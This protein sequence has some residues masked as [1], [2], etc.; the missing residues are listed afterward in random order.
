MIQKHSLFCGSALI[1]Y[2]EV[3]KGNEIFFIKK[4]I[5]CKEYKWNCE[6]FQNVFHKFNGFKENPKIKRFAL[7]DYDSNWFKIL[8]TIPKEILFVY[9]YIAT[10]YSLWRNSSEPHFNFIEFHEFCSAKNKNKV[11]QSWEVFDSSDKIE[12]TKNNFIFCALQK[13]I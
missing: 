8:Q 13:L 2:I 12:I 5:S 3:T 11:M 9:K 10:T 7:N 6:L 4:H 1:S